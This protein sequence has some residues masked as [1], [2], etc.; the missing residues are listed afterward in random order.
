MTKPLGLALCKAYYLIA[1]ALGLGYAFF[2]NPADFTYDLSL[3]WAPLTLATYALGLWLIRKRARITRTVFVAGT[4]ACA[5]LSVVDLMWMG[6]YDVLVAEMG[7]LATNTI[8]ALGLGGALASAAYLALSPSAR[9]VLCQEM[10]VEPVAQEGHSWDKPLRERIRTK[11]FW[12]DIAIYFTSFSFLGH[13]AEMLFCMGIVWGIFDGTYDFREVMLWHQWLFPYLA[14]AVAMVLVVVLLHPF[15][16]WLLHKMGGRVAPTL[17]LSILITAAVCTTIDFTAG[18]I[19]NQDYTVWDYRD[20]PFN[21]MGQVCLQ[22]S[23][24]YTLACTALVWIAYPLMDR[25]LRR[26]PRDAGTA[27]CIALVAVFVFCALLHFVY[28]NDVGQLTP[29]MVM[30]PEDA[31]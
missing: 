6:A 13:W 17:L 8:V 21:F 28:V 14:E 19:C 4:L 10:D 18:M 20:M 7:T 11:V 15:K 30:L 22:N 25:G 29:G 3:L 2:T 5:A 23:V 26:M 9:R 31:V 16:Q 24:V 1:I 27:L 12:R